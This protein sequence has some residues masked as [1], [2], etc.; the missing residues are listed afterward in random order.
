MTSGIESSEQVLNRPC[1]EIVFSADELRASEKLYFIWV[2]RPFKALRSVV[3]LTT[4]LKMLY[5]PTESLNPL[6]VYGSF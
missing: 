3:N 5:S 1:G 6:I 4:N 2:N